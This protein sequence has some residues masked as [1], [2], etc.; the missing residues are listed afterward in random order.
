MKQ[1]MFRLTVL[2]LLLG[3][4]DQAKAEILYKNGALDGTTDAWDIS[5]SAVTN[6]FTL[7]NDSNLT[8][9]RVGLWVA[10]DD[11]PLT[12]DWSIGTGPFDDDIDYGTADLTT[13]YQFTN[14]YGDDVYRCG[15][16][17][18]FAVSAGDYWL[19]LV[20]TTSSSGERVYW[21]A[22]DGPSP[23]LESVW[24]VIPSEYFRILGTKQM[25]RLWPKQLGR[26][27][28]FIAARSKLKYSVTSRRN[29][30]ARRSLDA[31]RSAQR[32]ASG[33]S[34]YRL[35]VGQVA[36]P[37]HPNEL[38]L[39]EQ[40]RRQGDAVSFIGHRVG[41]RVKV[42]DAIRAQSRKVD[43]CWP[44]LRRRYVASR[45]APERRA[46]W[47][48]AAVLYLLLRLQDEQVQAAAL[49]G[50]E[51]LRAGAAHC[52]VAE[53]QLALVQGNDSLAL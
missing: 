38:F 20:N 4:A 6:G 21:D 53:L 23:A 50:R 25:A 30:T 34:N 13:S 44:S 18:D 29:V 51:F 35:H 32:L 11:T 49:L 39:S 52:R 36:T 10:L 7:K 45:P 37:M 24:G 12:V 16:S 22:N 9:A 40:L 17:L 5:T 47:F 15:F 27:T 46:P 41:E 48:G 43:C 19:T 14:D 8:G 28:N 31:V 33:R 1:L 3:V 42:H 26:G 2:A